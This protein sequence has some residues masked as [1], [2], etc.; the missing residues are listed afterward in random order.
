MTIDT[1]IDRAAVSGRID[2]SLSY[3]GN[4]WESRLSGRP[5]VRISQINSRFQ[6]YEKRRAVAGRL[7]RRFSR[8][9]VK[10]G[11]EAAFV[12]VSENDLGV[13]H[14]L[15]DGGFEI[16]ECLLTFESTGPKESRSSPGIQIREFEK[17]DLKELER[18]GRT[19]FRYSRFHADPK[20]SR[21]LANRSRAEWVRNGCL[22]RASIVFVAVKDKAPVGFCL[23]RE[24]GQAGAQKG[25]IDLIAADGAHSGR[26]IGLALTKATVDHY[27]DKGMRVLVGT[28][29]KNIPSVNLYIKAG[30]RLIRS[31]LGLVKYF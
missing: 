28:Q 9:C 26:G 5:T 18:I 25:V 16:L 17:H 8:D 13:L 20:I 30:F 10:A 2:G 27:G 19:S 22:G 31:D 14:A 24:T 1:I 12:R 11:I 3:A 7:L 29:A 23:C 4:P 6:G 15:E 21:A